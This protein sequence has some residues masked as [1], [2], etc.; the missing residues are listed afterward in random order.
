[1]LVG[2]VT[3]T[4]KGDDASFRAATERSAESL[5]KVRGAAT[6]AAS[7]L[8]NTTAAAKAN[9][10]AAQSLG[11]TIHTTG[12]A[13]KQA[14]G[15][16][17]Q[18]S[19]SLAG[20]GGGA[21]KA[22]AAMGGL[23]QMIGSGGPVGIAVGAAV[24]AMAILNREMEE[25]EKRARELDEAWERVTRSATQGR[26]AAVAARTSAERS[27]A[28]LGSQGRAGSTAES[29][30][31]LRRRSALGWE[32]HAI[33][34]K[35]KEAEADTTEAG[36]AR[37][38][39]LRQ[40]QKQK[41]EEF[42]LVE[43]IVAEEKR[44]ADAAR[45]RADY[46]ARARRE[47]EAQRDLLRSIRVSQDVAAMLPGGGQLA[48]SA[49]VAGGDDSFGQFQLQTQMQAG[50]LGFDYG[51]RDK[52]AA[53]FEDMGKALADANKELRMLGVNLPETNK[54]VFEAR[55]GMRDFA[56]AAERARADMAASYVMAAATGT[57]GAQGG[58][59]VGAL[60]GG[61]IGSFFGGAALGESLGG[62]LGTILG[63]TLDALIESLQVLTPLFDAV[64]VI[65]KAL[66]P[67]LMV[68][69]VLFVAVGHTI[70]NLAPVI[71]ALAEPIAA[72]LLVVVRIVEALLPFAD[73]IILAAAGLLFLLEAI[74]ASVEALDAAFLR[75]MVQLAN[76]VYNAWVDVMNVLT[77]TIRDITGNKKYGVMLDK[78]S[79]ETDDVMSRFADSMAEI[80]AYG[81]SQEDA[82]RKGTRDGTKEGMD[83][84][85]RS[86]QNLPSGYKVAGA[87]FSAAN[88]TQTFTFNLSGGDVRGAFERARD[89]AR[90]GTVAP[91]M[92]R[93]G[94][95]PRRN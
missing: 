62:A 60:A 75:P 32:L 48:Q 84:W 79:I 14:A 18:L 30:E 50:G 64:G 3:A 69:E 65:I 53:A 40:T 16:M 61:L 92:G 10:Q 46:E 26:D 78:R 89:F 43:K 80:R 21:G 41:Q 73:V 25:Q 85:S 57:I 31:V 27:L 56:A 55:K 49:F 38:A 2:A 28:V 82:I 19:G 51:A 12:G 63:S 24:A 20:V 22:A 52:P 95:G 4:L 47:L 8:Q 1:M 66:A 15:A 86:T 76:I 88:V 9:E 39:L 17:G 59:E 7:A 91:T 94:I 67:I 93:R 44:V 5:R 58:A 68:L 74:T 90:S 35:I 45:A 83:A 77:Q 81:E 6:E 23:A 72:L 11:R 42:G 34:V 33:H 71:H 37:L 36:R 70:E 87:E 13:V 54:S 29:D